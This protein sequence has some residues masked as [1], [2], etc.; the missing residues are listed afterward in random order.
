MLSDSDTPLVKNQTA[1]MQLLTVAKNNH[2][3]SKTANRKGICFS[4]V[5][6]T[7]V[8]TVES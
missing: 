7:H 5:G 4:G 6:F 2:L 8:F 1:A 3:I